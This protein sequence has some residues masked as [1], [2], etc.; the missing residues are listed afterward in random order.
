MTAPLSGTLSEGTDGLRGFDCNARLTATIARRFFDHGYRFAVRY[1]RRQQ[2]HA[3][4]LRTE[5]AQT[6]LNVGLGLM[7]VQHVESAESWIP[8]AVKGIAY[9]SVAAREMELVGFPAGSMCWCDLEGVALGTHDA[10]VID[11]CNH[12]H[13][14]V[15]EAGFLPGLYVGWHAGL[16]A[17]QLYRN[18]RFTRYWSSYNL[19]A[20]ELPVKRGVCMKQHVAKPGD[21]PTGVTFEIDTD[22]ISADALGGRPTLL[23]RE[24]P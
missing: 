11:Y 15:S 9:G 24:Q 3:Y 2:Y 10:S 4:D 8:S 13:Q 19:N 21:R 6:I 7:A 14:Q 16:S 22:T 12:W 5:E 17:L 20:D 18:L 1:V 23:I